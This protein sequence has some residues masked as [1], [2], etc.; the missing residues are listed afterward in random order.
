MRGFSKTEQALVALELI[1]R[2]GGAAGAT[3]PRGLALKRRIQRGFLHLVTGDVNSALC[4]AS[5]DWA[6]SSCS[7]LPAAT[8]VDYTE[9]SGEM[10]KR[11]AAKRKAPGSEDGAASTRA[12]QGR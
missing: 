5:Q 8:K 7:T 11:Q 3:T 2:G 10:R 9:L 6:S 4:L 1:R 12:R